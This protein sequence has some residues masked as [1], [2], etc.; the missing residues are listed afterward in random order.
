[1]ETIKISDKNS[2]YQLSSSAVLLTGLR[3]VTGWLFFSAFWRRLI[4]ENKLDPDGIGYVGEKFNHFFPNAIFVKPMIHFMITHPDFLQIFLIV[5]TIIEALVG[6]GLLFGIFTRASALG[7][8]LLSFGILFGAGWL[9]TTCLD[10]WQIGAF[11]IIAGLIMIVAGADK[12]SLDRLLLSRLTKLKEK[13]W[14]KYMGSGDI[15]ISNRIFTYISL[16]IAMFSLIITLYT[17]QVFHGGVWGKL[18]NLSMKPNIVISETKYDKVKGLRFDLF[19]DQGI[20]TYG[21]FITRI[22]LKD[23]N[24]ELLEEYSYS[25]LSKIPDGDIEN[26]YI[27]KVKKGKNSLIIPLGAKA[28]VTLPITV[29]KEGG[30]WIEV[31]DI[32]GKVWKESFRIQ[33]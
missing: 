17:N 6:L 26:Y 10:E 28:K 18:H 9:G 1:M 27:A 7:V 5:F 8:F 32:S 25:E 13:K 14:F 11:G 12:F 23:E 19:R 2:Q 24:G 4:L 16:F 3:W 29:S 30:Y 22:S 33:N 21:A 20:D 15:N 31:E